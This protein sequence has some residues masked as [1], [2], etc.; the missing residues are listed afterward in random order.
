MLLTLSTTREPATD[1]GFLLHKNPS[2][3]RSE[4]L[5]FGTAHVFYPEAG[6]R[7]AT[8]ALL[9]EVDPVG[10]VSVAL[11]RLFNTATS[12][13]SKERPELARTPLRLRSQPTS[14]FPDGTRA[15]TPM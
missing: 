10:F 14:A 9:L 6:H 12:G 8:A 3:V 7:R 4:Q 1:L 2:S 11:A 5:W 13:R 15:R